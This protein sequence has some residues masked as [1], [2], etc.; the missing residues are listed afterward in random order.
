MNRLTFALIVVCIIGNMDADIVT[1]SDEPVRCEGHEG[2]VGA[3]AL[4]PDGKLAVSSDH[5]FSARVWD[6]INGTQL[7]TLQVVPPHA[8]Y[9]YISAVAFSPDGKSVVTA[10]WRQPVCFWDPKT[11][12]RLDENLPV[13]QAAYSL[14]F[15]PDGSKL[16]VGEHSAVKVWDLRSRKV[17]HDFQFEQNQ[18]GQA[19]RVVF[20]PDGTLLAAAL[21]DYGG[22]FVPKA[23]KV[24]VWNVAT[25]NEVFS[26]WSNRSAIA[27]AVSRD[28]KLAAAGDRLIEI[29]DLNTQ[30]S[31][32]R[33]A[34]DDRII[35][36][37]A[38]TPDGRTIVTGWNDPDI[39]FW[40]VATGE[41]VA[42]L[43]SAMGRVHYLCFSGDGKTL[44]IAGND[45]AM[46]MWPCINGYPEIQ[47]D[48]DIHK[49]Q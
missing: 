37:L 35:S 19:W 15:S 18:I 17:L 28:G 48:S 2:G 22:S 20:S 45:T 6:A 39:T 14:A 9:G 5:T 41:K 7:R 32:R 24:R 27:I 10:A 29:W 21:L 42:A 47:H 11:G 1:A 43:E 46:L 12:E 8:E 3:V 4:S 30:Q 25:G 23:P 44:A 26:A 13:K 31:L 34:A 40:D 38:F 33:I 36:C 16:A 49:E